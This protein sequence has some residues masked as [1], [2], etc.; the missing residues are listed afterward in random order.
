MI[1]TFERFLHQLVFLS[2]I[3][4]WRDEVLAL[5]HVNMRRGDQFEK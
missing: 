1:E 2:R 3:H 4:A 5:A